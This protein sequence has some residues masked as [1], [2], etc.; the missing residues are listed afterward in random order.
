[1]TSA[2]QG[3]LSGGLPYLAVGAGPPVVVLP[4]IS[5]D[6]ADPQGRD[7]RTQARAFRSLTSRFTVY[8]IN[9]RPG[10]RAGAT[11]RD[12]ADDYAC[13]IAHEFGGPVPVIGVS[14]GG[15][16]AQL[17]AADHPRLVSRLVLVA[18]AHRLAE[19]GRRVQRALA[20]YAE[21]GRPR[22]AWAATGT[23]LA[24][25]TAG[26]CC[27]TVLLW[28]MGARMTPADPTDLLITV[29]AEDAF[30]AWPDLPRITAP[31]LVIGGAR[32][33]FYTP[34]SFRATAERI[35]GGRLLL[36]RTKG[37]VGS[38]GSPATA[39]VVLHYLITGE[40]QARM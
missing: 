39:R 37:H 10:L 25:G 30:D 11:I 33:G 22:R 28:L 1:M 16:I 18:S 34:E 36:Y 23:A 14:T 19:P 9:R 2:R 4:G 29:A 31:A 5:G 40:V 24:G 21:A 12:L 3:I 38:A 13:A 7:R 15:S 26:R 8:V 6:N 32:D 17:L 20:R 35:P 27:F